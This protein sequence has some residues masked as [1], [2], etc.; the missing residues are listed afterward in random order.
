MW[1]LCLLQKRQKDDWDAL[2]GWTFDEAQTH[3]EH[4]QA[5]Q[6]RVYSRASH[7]RSMLSSY[8]Q[9]LLHPSHT[10]AVPNAGLQ[11]LV[12]AGTRTD[13]MLLDGNSSCE[14][15]YLSVSCREPVSRRQQANALLHSHCHDSL[16]GAARFL[17]LGL[18]A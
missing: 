8:A 10:V 16:G 1:P 4:T 7:F 6:A 11:L 14:T 18:Q 17:I 9:E 15:T 5:A 2:L 12:L 3:F 13:I